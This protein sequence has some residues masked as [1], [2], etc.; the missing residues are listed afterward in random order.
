MIP[1][2]YIG[3]RA[4]KNDYNHSATATFWRSAIPPCSHQ[5]MHRGRQKNLCSYPVY[6]WSRLSS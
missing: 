2:L 1:S 5:S 3:P 4:L 6:C